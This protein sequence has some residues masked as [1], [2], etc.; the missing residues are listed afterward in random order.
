MEENVF[1][2]KFGIVFISLNAKVTQAT[3]EKNEITNALSKSKA[4][5]QLKKPPKGVDPWEVLLVSE[6]TALEILLVSDHTAFEILLVSD[7]IGS[8]LLQI[9]KPIEILFCTNSSWV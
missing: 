9:I 5:K 4:N 3:K 6:H 7:T 2:K 8:Q 1:Q